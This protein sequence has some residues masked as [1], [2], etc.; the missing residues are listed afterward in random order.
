MGKTDIMVNGLPGNVAK[1]MAILA[2]KNERFNVIFLL[3]F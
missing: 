2:L 1:I 3:M